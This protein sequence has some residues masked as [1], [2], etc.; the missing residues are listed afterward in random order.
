[1]QNIECNSS[2]GRSPNHNRKSVKVALAKR[3][4][5]AAQ[6][7]CQFGARKAKGTLI[8]NET[9]PSVYGPWKSFMALDLR[10]Q[11]GSPFIVP[12]LS[13]TNPPI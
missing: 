5:S 6:N 9:K 10:T 3:L 4:G 13:T 2:A 8:A 11:Y 7:F 12:L 1:M